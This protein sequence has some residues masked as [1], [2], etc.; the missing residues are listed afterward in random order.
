MPVNPI[1]FD[2]T[3]YASD[4]EIDCL[5]VELQAEIRAVTAVTQAL[6]DCTFLLPVFLAGHSLYSKPST[7]SF[8][9]SYVVER[10]SG[11]TH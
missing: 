5:I 11:L 8:D 9:S 7:A 2:P 3:Y 10:S 4:Y 6:A 1:Y